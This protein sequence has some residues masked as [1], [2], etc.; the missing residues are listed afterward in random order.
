MTNNTNRPFE[1][2]LPEGS[3]ATSLLAGADFHDTWGVEAQ[4]RGQSA[5]G[6]FIQ[7]A[8][9]TPHWVDVC[10]DLR[11]RAGALVGLKNLGRLASVSGSKP[12]EDYKAGE[13]VSI[14]TVFENSFEEALIGDK[15]KHLDVF[16]SIHR[17]Q[18]GENDRALVR[19][20][21]IVHVKN[22]LGRIY[23]LPVRPMHRLIA[24]AMLEAFNSH[25]A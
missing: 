11:N 1:A 12:A 25:Q 13:R 17:A 10:M 2:A 6:L 14:F 20:T 22:T 9:C 7:A 8:A 21:T 15:D 4:T 16:L 24:P 18:D 19:V 5:L 23:M 3:R